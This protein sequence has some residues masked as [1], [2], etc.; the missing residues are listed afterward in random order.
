[1]ELNNKKRFRSTFKFQFQYSNI[2]SAHFIMNESIRV[3]NL[4]KCKMPLDT[5]GFEFPTFKFTLETITFVDKLTFAFK[6]FPQRNR[7]SVKTKIN[8]GIATGFCPRENK[9]RMHSILMGI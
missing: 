1:M 5:R 4:I 3:G 9:T 8:T 7:S 2:N 6:L